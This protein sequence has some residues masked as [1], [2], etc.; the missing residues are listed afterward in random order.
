MERSHYLGAVEVPDGYSGA[1]TVAHM[2]L[3]EGH[4]LCAH[5][6][7]FH[8]ESILQ[9]SYA[10]PAEAD[11]YLDNHYL[12]EVSWMKF[13]EMLYCYFITLI[14]GVALGYAWAYYH[15]QVLP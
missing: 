10:S 2:V 5:P 12:Q 6:W 8:P 7:G 15:F 4:I 1:R 9:L 14:L 13:F 3:F 11:W